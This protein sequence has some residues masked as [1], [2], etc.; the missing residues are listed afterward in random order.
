M[1][2]DSVGEDGRPPRLGSGGGVIERARGLL[3]AEG[4]GDKAGEDASGGT[5]QPPITGNVSSSDCAFGS[6]SF[7]REETKGGSLFPRLS[8]VFSEPLVA[9]ALPFV[10]GPGLGPLALPLRFEEGPAMAGDTAELDASAVVGRRRVRGRF[11]LRS[12]SCTGSEG[13][14]V[15]DRA[16]R[17]RV[18]GVA[19]S[20]VSLASSRAPHARLSSRVSSTGGG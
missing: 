7:S 5:R 17:L 10:T 20:S 3:W 13:D 1:L 6:S 18:L 11:S 14:V 15:M 9:T 16:F 19:V 8:L 12:G 4:D 2:S